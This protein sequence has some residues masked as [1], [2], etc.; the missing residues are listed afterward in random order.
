M[1]RIV[2]Q[3]T[4]PDISVFLDRSAW[5]KGCPEAAVAIGYCGG[6]LAPPTISANGW[7]ATGRP[8]AAAQ[9]DTHGPGGVLRIIF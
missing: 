5:F 4:P 2:R 6:S 3:I 1:A 8:S 7:Q 9:L